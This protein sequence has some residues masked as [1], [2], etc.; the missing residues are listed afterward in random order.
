MLHFIFL[1]YVHNIELIE[2]LSK[3]NLLPK[4]DRQIRKYIYY[5]I[6]YFGKSLKNKKNLC[7]KKCQKRDFASVTIVEMIIKRI[8]MPANVFFFFK[9][10]FK[11]LL[12][13]IQIKNL[14]FWIRKNLE[15][16][17]YFF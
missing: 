5:R 2:S 6:N 17:I 10:N 7:L 4:N 12:S 9:E 16:G 1:S 3:R 15:R 14:I 8:L 13:E 11:F